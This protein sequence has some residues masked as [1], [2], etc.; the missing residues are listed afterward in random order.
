MSLSRT[1]AWVV[2]DLLLAGAVG[3]AMYGSLQHPT[4]QSGLFWSPS[5]PFLLVLALIGGVIAFW[6]WDQSEGKH[7]KGGF[8]RIVGVLS[9]GTILLGAASYWYCY[10]ERMFFWA[11]ILEGLTLFTGSYDDPFG[12]VALP[13]PSSLPVGLQ[14]ARVGAFMTIFASVLGL[15]TGYLKNVS[16]RSWVHWRTSHTIV[17]GSGSAGLATSP[18]EIAEDVRSFISMKKRL[19]LPSV[20][21]SEQE[22]ALL[23][24]NNT[25][26]IELNMSMHE[27]INKNLARISQRTSSI[28]FID[29]NPEA[30]I[31][32]FET[33][34]AS[35]DTAKFTKNEIVHGILRIDDHWRGDEYRRNSLNIS[36]NCFVDVIS[37]Y[38][39]TARILAERLLQENVSEVVILGQ[40]PLVQALL[41]EFV[42]RD[43][44]AAGIQQTEETSIASV[45]VVGARAEDLVRDYELFQRRF[46]SWNSRHQVK[47]VPIE[48]SF[49]TL[50][51]MQGG[52]KRIAIIYTEE[53]FGGSAQLPQQLAVRY[54]KCLQYLFSRSISGISGQ[55]MLGS[56]YGFG[57]TLALEEGFTSGIWG[58][59]ARL[60]HQRFLNDI[61]EPPT[62]TIASRKPWDMGLD[63]FYKL[64]N[65]RPILNLLYATSTLGMNWLPNQAAAHASQM[66]A[67]ISQG[68]LAQ[69]ARSEH[70]SWVDYMSGAGWSNGK[71]NDALKRHPDLVPWAALCQESIRK[72][73]AGVFDTM[74][75]LALMGFH[76]YRISGKD[77]DA[78][79]WARYVRFGEVEAALLTVSTT[80]KTDNGD[81]LVGDVGD[82]EISH[83]GRKWTVKPDV[84]T[85]S[86][87]FVGEKRWQRIGAVFARTS[88]TDDHLDTLEGEASSK[89]KDMILF[90]LL[91]ETWA[92]SPEEF[93]RSYREDL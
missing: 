55:A 9:L 34:I 40:S 66:R 16:D 85:K 86:Y 31:D 62:T 56:L 26:I 29:S 92:V 80:W 25:S 74:E 75:L 46:G 89:P 83:E 49:E 61:G 23:R 50:A 11:P 48:P 3:I 77:Q 19:I 81:V 18:I 13:C 10:P 22:I 72:N 63:R 79:G 64:G 28:F 70:D 59:M 71:R 7:R 52:D 5:S 14:M 45:H 36:P 35:R 54:P 39:S 2:G 91:G 93:H 21:L 41:S 4:D 90:G 88:L 30:N 1:V 69:L 33:F 53:P 87:K 20:G 17:V 82:W 57:F 37:V 58:R 60:K 42:I 44:E 76:P 68:E 84:F 15:L 27:T 12:G 51:S 43:R 78:N 67:R 73:V 6:A 38:S 8:L 47:H 65:V 32:N 24:R